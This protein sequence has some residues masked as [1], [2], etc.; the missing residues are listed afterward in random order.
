MPKPQGSETRA[1]TQSQI[2]K[3]GG[4]KIDAWTGGPRGNE[5]T[6]YV[7]PIS[8][9]LSVVYDI[10]SL[11]SP[12]E[13]PRANLGKYRRPSTYPIAADVPEHGAGELTEEQRRRMVIGSEIT[14]VL[15]NLLVASKAE[16][17]IV[18][19]SRED[20][21]RWINLRI[22]SY[23]QEFLFIGPQD[24]PLPDVRAV[25]YEGQSIYFPTPELL[26]A[27]GVEKRAEQPKHLI[28]AKKPFEPGLLGIRGKGKIKVSVNSEQG[29]DRISIAA[30]AHF[31]GVNVEYFHD[32]I[33]EIVTP[34]QALDF[35][36][37]DEIKARMESI[38]HSIGSLEHD[39]R[40]PDA[41]DREI[42][43]KIARLHADLAVYKALEQRLFNNPYAAADKGATGSEDDKDGQI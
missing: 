9:A 37:E 21:S 34:Q 38:E 32:G 24:P 42:D 6:T 22:G 30:L 25:E 26:D 31:T 11:R 1:T 7:D 15:W 2:E 36:P 27:Y 43:I 12:R 23:R 5:I 4:I 29:S 33:L 40:E 10:T 35:I 41:S 14:H 28:D 17:E 3:R 13:N 39:R 16:G 18:G 8:R 19:I 20:Y